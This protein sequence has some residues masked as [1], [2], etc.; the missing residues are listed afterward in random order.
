MLRGLM[1]LEER[2]VLDAVGDAGADR[3]LVVDKSVQGADDLLARVGAFFDSAY[4]QIHSDMLRRDSVFF[5]HELLRLKQ[6][7]IDTVKTE[8]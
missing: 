1:R 6:G 5:D 2:I 3:I 7:I 8:F 4:E